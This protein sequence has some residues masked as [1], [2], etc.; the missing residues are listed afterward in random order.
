M[1]FEKLWLPIVK[2]K[3]A[4]PVDHLGKRRSRA[5]AEQMWVEVEKDTPIKDVRLHIYAE[6]KLSPLSQKLFLRGSEVEAS[7]TVE[8]LRIADGD[9]LA[10]EEIEEADDFGPDSGPE[11]FGGTALIGRKGELILRHVE[12]TAACPACTYS[13][14]P[15]HLQCAMCET[16]L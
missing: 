10:L 3:N 5:R 16:Q 11:G 9:F 6:W 13:N 7:D 12:L 2:G 15:M 1:D 14:E 8:S 4:V